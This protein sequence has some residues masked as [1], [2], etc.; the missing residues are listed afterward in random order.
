MT[1]PQVPQLVG[2][3]G[4]LA[5][6]PENT[7]LGLDAA[8]QAGACW[9]EF[10]VQRCADGQF[11]LLHD[12][13]LQRTA[14]DSRSVF[15]LDSQTLAACS[16]HEPQRFGN[17]FAGATVPR[18]AAVLEWLTGFP[19]A[20]AMV[21]IK[22]ESPDHWGLEPVM[23]PLLAQLEP[24]RDQC[25][26]ISFSYAA[27][28]F[29][30]Q[31]SRVETGWVL[32]RYDERHR[33]QAQALRPDFLICNENKL[34]SQWQ[35]WP[36]PWKWMLYDIIDPQRAMAWAAQGVTLIETADIGAMLQHPLLAGS[37]C[38]HGL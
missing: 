38:R 32:S 21:E 1:D 22:A 34:S 12:S 2:H 37:A 5:R 30:K 14:G 26:L 27:I 24:F 13:D 28:A 4:Y 18:L 7:R 10:D 11:V 15:E 33:Q 16:V 20:R 3:R 29:A 25:V 19:R 35:P 36:G 6:Y 17:R 8:L 9:L 31:R 23:D